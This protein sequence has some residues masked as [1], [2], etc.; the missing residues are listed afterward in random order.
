[1]TAIRVK[2]IRWT[3]LHNFIVRCTV[4]LHA[5]LCNNIQDYNFVYPTYTFTAVPT[6]GSSVPFL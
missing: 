6:I 2:S 3:H 1:M 5:V 4:A